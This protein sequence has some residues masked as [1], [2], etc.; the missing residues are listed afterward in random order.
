MYKI[1]KAFLFQIFSYTKSTWQLRCRSGSTS[2]CS[3]PLYVEP[4]P[5]TA[6]VRF[7]KVPANT[8]VQKIK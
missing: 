8:P 2:R 5:V 1:F 7:I 3:D 4:F 6:T